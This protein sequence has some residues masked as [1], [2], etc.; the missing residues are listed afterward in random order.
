MR[1]WLRI[2]WGSEQ[3]LLPCVIASWTLAQKEDTAGSCLE[4]L[5]LTQV[6]AGV[7]KEQEL[8]GST[9]AAPVPFAGCS[10]CHV[11]SN[12]RLPQVLRSL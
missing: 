8:G 2:C 11:W 7:R 9:F 1:V 12:S 6:P 3:E 10:G 5:T 4:A